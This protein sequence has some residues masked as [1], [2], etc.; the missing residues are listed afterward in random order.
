MIYQDDRI[1]NKQPVVSVFVFTYNQEKIVSKTIESIL[2]QKTT[3]AYELIIAEDCSKDST[4]QICVDYQK[5][6]PDLIRVIGNDYNKGM[7]RNFHESISLYAR[8]KYIAE[9]AGDDWWHNPYKIQKQV[10]FLENNPDYGLVFSDT[11]V[12]SEKKKHLLKYK[13][14]EK[15]CSFKDL[16]I[17]NSIDALT[18]CYRKDLFNK[19]VK[20]IDPVNEGFP[21]EDY[22]LWIWFSYYTKLYH[23]KEPLTTYRLQQSSLSHSDS[24]I[25]R[26]Q[27]EIDRLNLKL[28]FYDY[29][30]LN[31]VDILYDIYLVYYFL[32]LNSAS[33]AKNESIETERLKFFKNNGCY[34]FYALAKLNQRFASNRVMSSTLR[35][36]IKV[37]MKFRLI[38]KYSKVYNKVK[39]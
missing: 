30:N 11:L 3:Y 20:D 35:F 22:P 29:F 7:V 12:Y 31:D 21:G 39:S 28:F 6:Y 23:I 26:L 1:L 25:R 32:T 33:E 4:L 5:K 16:I 14:Y 2:A 38:D 19:Y 9:V 15:P 37:C 34:L 13:P 8:G 10:D 36:V 18:T 17:L 27:F 24:K